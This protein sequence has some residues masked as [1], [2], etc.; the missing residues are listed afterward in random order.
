MSFSNKWVRNGILNEKQ[1]HW[2]W[3]DFPRYL[4]PLLLRIFERF[5]VRLVVIV[6]VWS[7]LICLPNHLFSQFRL[8]GTQIAFKIRI[9]RRLSASEEERAKA[10]K[11]TGADII[12]PSLLPEECPADALDREWTSYYARA[13]THIPPTPRTLPH[14]IRVLVRY[15]T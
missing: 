15:V 6:V 3:L 5:Q 13:G 10:E 12:V 2:V 14:F 8:G 9:A 1:L 4:H 7:G 11:R